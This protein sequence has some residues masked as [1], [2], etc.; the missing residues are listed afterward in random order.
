MPPGVLE[1][2]PGLAHAPQPMHRHGAPVLPHQVPPQVGQELL[3]PLEERAQRGK[4]QVARPVGG[5]QSFALARRRRPRQWRLAGHGASERPESLLDRREPRPSRALGP[6]DQLAGLLRD[7]ALA[8]DLP[9]RSRDRGDQG[10]EIG[11]SQIGQGSHQGR[12]VHGGCP[13]WNRLLGGGEV[14]AFF[15]AG[16][17]IV[18][19]N[20]LQRIR[21]VDLVFPEPCVCL[22][23][24]QLSGLNRT[25]ARS[26]VDRLRNKNPFAVLGSVKNLIR[27]RVNT[28]IPRC[29]RLC[30]L[31]KRDSFLSAIQQSTF[32]VILSITKAARRTLGDSTESFSKIVGPAFS[33][34]LRPPKYHLV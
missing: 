18:Q 26:P 8:A 23:G 33:L 19:I 10:G 12:S 24:C 27:R 17:H 5:G 15:L 13:P 7:R 2:C 21:Q 20:S 9:R 28:A 31:I 4:R 25:F 32:N 29:A 6:A 30:Q 3:P 1:R 16:V 22:G 11:R 34:S 14:T